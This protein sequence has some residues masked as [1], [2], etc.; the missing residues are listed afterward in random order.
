MKREPSLEDIATVWTTSDLDRRRDTLYVLR[1]G[2]PQQ[3]DDRKVV[4]FNEAARMLS[5]TP[6]S[7]RYA[8]DAAGIKAVKLP[9]RQRAF[10]LRTTDVAKLAGYN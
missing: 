2:L 6:R 5:I 7:L 3:T 4:R 1:N 9:G 10:G 8:V